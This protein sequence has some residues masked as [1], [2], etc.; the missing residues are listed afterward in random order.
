MKKKKKRILDLMELR[1]RMILK[2]FIGKKWQKII[3]Y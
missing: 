3:I 2:L 1:D